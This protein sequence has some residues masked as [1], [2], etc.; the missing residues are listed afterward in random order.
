VSRSSRLFGILEPRYEGKEAAGRAK[1]WK[2][3][4]LDKAIAGA[5]ALGSGR[6]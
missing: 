1:R 4:V 6:T 2:R 3:S 5:K